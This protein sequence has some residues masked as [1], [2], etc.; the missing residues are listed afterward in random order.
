MRRLLVLL[1]LLGSAPAA[2]AAPARLEARAPV[3]DVHA[4]VLRVGVRCRPGPCTGVVHAVTLDG[5]PLT[6][7]RRVR[8][9]S[10]RY[11]RVTLPFRRGGLVELAEQFDVAE[12]RLQSGRRTRTAGLGEPRLAVTCRDGTTLAAGTEVRV[13]RVAGWGVFGCAPESSGV[14]TIA[15]ES[16]AI[17]GSASVD[18]VTVAGPFV[19][20]VQSGGWKCGSSGVGLFDVRAHRVVRQRSTENRYESSANGCGGT[21]SVGEVVVRATGA[22]AWTELPGDDDAARVRALDGGG[23][24]LLDLAPDVDPRSL[25]LGPGGTVTWRHAGLVRSA[26]LR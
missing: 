1:A 16:E 24:R 13:L 20:F 26:P 4:D 14:H 11:T 21:T 6:G 7:G 10:D 3:A 18:A 12:V 9:R 25:A 15:R 23:D 22:M 5:I 19:A 17:G 8:L 2:A